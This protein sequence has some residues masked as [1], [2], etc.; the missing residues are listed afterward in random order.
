MGLSST[1]DPMKVTDTA[2]EKAIKA[3]Q[4]AVEAGINLLDHADIY[5]TT[6]CES[7]FKECLA[8]LPNGR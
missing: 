1:W 8:A 3:V 2:I 6:T 5:G 4:T 7:I